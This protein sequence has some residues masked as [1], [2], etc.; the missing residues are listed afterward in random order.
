MKQKIVNL[1]QMKDKGI[2]GALMLYQDDRDLE[3]FKAR[4]VDKV[5]TPS[6][7]QRGTPTMS[8]QSRST[9]GFQYSANRGQQH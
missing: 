8:Q 4:V 7:S 2:L 9:P 1:V 3:G 6:V 5:L